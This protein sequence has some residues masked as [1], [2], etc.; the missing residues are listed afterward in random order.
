MEKFEEQMMRRCIQLAQLG[1]GTTYPNPL[2]G[3]VIVHENKIVAEGWHQKYGSAHAEVNAIQQI[4]DKEILRNS[5]LYVSLE[6][7]AHHGKTPPCAD[8]IIQCQIPRVVVGTSD[9]FAKVNGLGIQKMKEAGIDVKLGLL[10]HECREL[11]KRFFTFHEKKRPYIILKWAQTADGF[12]APTTGK[13]KWITNKF[14]KQLVHKW[15]TEEQGILVGTNTAQVDNPELNARLWEGNNPVRMVLDRDLKLNLNLN[16][17]NRNQK[18]LV[19]TEEPNTNSEN[20]EF[21]PIRFDENLAEQILEELYEREIQSVIIEGGK[22]TLETFIRKGLW[23]EARIF[24]SLD[25][26]S[27]GIHSPEISGQIIETRNIAG[28][29]L[30]IFR[31]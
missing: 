22:Q 7:C 24:T 31:K 23:D 3:C 10:E 16:L 8:L 20:L 28:N 27:E 13:Q 25:N 12:M 17:F 30:E 1:L 11:N 14:S 6:P 18:T 19:F 4:S 5:T 21:I 26:W 15:R 29:K 9:P 2:V